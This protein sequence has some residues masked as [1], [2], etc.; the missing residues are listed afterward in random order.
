LCAAG[1][2][3]NATLAAIVNNATAG[4]ST[5]LTALGFDP[6]ETPA[7]ISAVQQYYPTVRK[8]ACL[9]DGNTFCVT[10]LLTDIQDAFGPLTISNIPNIVKGFS[11][12][13]VPQ[14]L[15]CSNCSKAAFNVVNQ[16]VPGLIPAS[17]AQQECGASFTD[18]QNPSGVTQTS[19]DTAQTGGSGNS[20]LSLSVVPGVS[21]LVALFGAFTLLA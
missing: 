18:G 3:S 12:N 17:D 9:K 21:A 14:N 20:A 19:S 16:D 15:T 11:V 8:V 13:S 1:P 10:E 4:C 2:C 5:E 6:S 7:V